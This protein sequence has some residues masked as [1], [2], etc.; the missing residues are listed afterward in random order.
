MPPE[1]RK[2]DSA[3]IALTLIALP[4][5]RDASSVF[6]FL[7]LPDEVNT[8]PIVEKA[9]ADRKRVYVPY[10]VPRT[11]AIALAE[12]TDP[13][14]DLMKGAFGIPEPREELRQAGTGIDPLSID[15]FIIPGASFD[16]Q[17]N[18]LGKG[19]GYFDRFLKDIKG[20]KPVIGLCYNEQVHPYTIPA[21]EH[22][23]RPDL[24]I[25]PLETIG[26]AKNG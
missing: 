21:Y 16:H 1:K 15:L 24:V 14:N 10:C 6:C 23:I 4:A 9:L 26:E 20:K 17:L 8:F 12:I 18:R 3:R 2:A 22:D 13:G 7:S 11:P 5:Y 25:T 19:G